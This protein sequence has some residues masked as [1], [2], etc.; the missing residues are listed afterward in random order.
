VD[1]KRE[2]PLMTNVLELR[3]LS[4]SW[5]LSI[6]ADAGGQDVVHKLYSDPIL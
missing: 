5:L 1:K 3:I 6:F 4:L 2:M